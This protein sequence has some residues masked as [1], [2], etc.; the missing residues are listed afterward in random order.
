MNY[1]GLT[2]GRAEMAGGDSALEFLGRAG[3]LARGIMYIVI[4]WIAL[5]IAFGSLAKAVVYAVLG[6]GVLKYAIGAGAP[7]S[8]NKQSVDLTATLLRHTGGQVLVVVIGLALIG[9][10]LYLGYQAWRERFLK[11][12]ELGQLQ[13]RSRRVVEWLGRVGGIAR[14]I[15]SCSACSPAARPAGVDSKTDARPHRIPLNVTNGV[16]AQ[17]RGCRSRLYR[18][19]RVRRCNY[20]CA[21]PPD[22]RPRRVDCG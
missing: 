12:R 3:F 2:S 7:Q 14:G 1:T 15:V 13:R 4:G 22:A 17:L 21:H 5:Q 8:S 9:G 19:I 6:Y 10:G 16:T 20:R 11:E 18:L